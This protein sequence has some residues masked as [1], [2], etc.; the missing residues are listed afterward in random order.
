ME[1][2]SADDNGNVSITTAPSP[3]PAPVTDLKKG[4]SFIS[5][6]P[7]CKVYPLMPIKSQE[8]C[9]LKWRPLKIS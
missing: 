4:S 3:V 5:K 8:P 9:R 2:K 6:K 1:D 7:S